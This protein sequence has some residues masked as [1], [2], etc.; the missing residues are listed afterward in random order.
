M[1]AS[2]LF[3]L[4]PAR[5]L[6]GARH[7]PPFVPHV[8]NRPFVLARTAVIDGDGRAA[9]D[10]ALPSDETGAL[11]LDA[12]SG[13]GQAVILLAAAEVGDEM[14]DSRLAACSRPVDS[15]PSICA[16]WPEPPPKSLHT[17]PRRTREAAC[18]DGAAAPT[19]W[20]SL[21]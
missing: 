15:P 14:M 17:G 7:G 16:A 19:R 4:W 12:T 13:G 6:D 18:T 20:R 2:P 21:Q 9:F 5:R 1:A 11:A 3:R 10:D 8:A